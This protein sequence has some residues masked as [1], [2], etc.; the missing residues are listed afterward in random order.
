MFSLVGLF[1]RLSVCILYV[2]NGK[3]LEGKDYLIL[4]LYPFHLVLHKAFHI[5][6]CRMTIK[7]KISEETVSKADFKLLL[8]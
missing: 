3:F 6:A 7:W 1:L 4:S 8:I 2:V 5:V